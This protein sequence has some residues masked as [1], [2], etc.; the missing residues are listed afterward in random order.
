LVA[1]LASDKTIPEL[2]TPAQLGA[3]SSMALDFFTQSPLIV[4]VR[5][6]SSPLSFREFAVVTDVAVSRCTDM[7]RF[8]TIPLLLSPYG[9]TD[10]DRALT[11]RHPNCQDCLELPA[12]E[13][14]A[15]ARDVSG[16]DK[17]L[18]YEVMQWVNSAEQTEG[19]LAES[20]T[21]AM[22]TDP[23]FMNHVTRH[24]GEVIDLTDR[25]LGAYRITEEI[26]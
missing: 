13:R 5:E 16:N 18:F 6:L 3:K 25:R 10:F 12:H 14:L 23:S 11:T 22:N 2:A 19:F 21:L 8:Q 26:A 24:A 7:P 17:V 9:H 4:S 15:H 20:A 1:A